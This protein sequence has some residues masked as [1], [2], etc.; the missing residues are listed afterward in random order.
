LSNVHVI[1]GQSILAGQHIGGSGN[2]GNSS[3]AHLHF[4]WDGNG[5]GVFTHDN[6]ADNPDNVLIIGV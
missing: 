1:E 5:D 4:G 2:T 3:G 6:S